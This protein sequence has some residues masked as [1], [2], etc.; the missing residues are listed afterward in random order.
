MNRKKI[1]AFIL[2]TSLSSP[3]ISQPL[4]V[5]AFENKEVI[6]KSE[7]GVKS[8]EDNNAESEVNENIITNDEKNTISVENTTKNVSVSDVVQIPDDNLKAALNEKLGVSQSDADITK[9][10]LESITSLLIE[11]R[12][13]SNLE[14]LQYCTNLGMLWLGDNQINDIS[15]LA[16]LTKL[17]TLR[18]NS[19]QISDISHLYNLT[20]LTQLDLTSNQISDIYSLASL[21][22]LT[23]LKLANNQI[24]D[25]SHLSSLTKLTNLIL[26]M[27]QTIDLNSLV[28][29]TNL[30]NLK[31]LELSNCQISDISSLE[32]ANWPNLTSLQL[33]KNQISDISPLA[34]L[35]SLTHLYL[36]NN[37]ISDISPLGNL[38]NLEY[39]HLRH[40]RISDVSPLVNW[41]NLSNLTDIYLGYNQISD[42][43]SLVNLN[44]PSLA[45]LDLA[46]NQISDASPLS[47]VRDNLPKIK[48]ITVDSQTIYL[49]TVELDSTS[50]EVENKIKDINGNIVDRITINN[51]GSYNSASKLVRWD[52][53]TSKTDLTYTF[54]ETMSMTGSGIITYFSGTVIQPYTIKS[55]KVTFDS[56]GGSNVPE[57]DVEFDSLIAKPT[58]PTREGYTFGGWY[59][60]ADCQNA[61]DFA[62]EKMPSNNVTLY[63]KWTRNSYNVNFDSQGGSAVGP[64]SVE[65]EGLVNKP[66]DPTREGYTFGGWY[67]D[68]T[69]A[70]AWNFDS[71]KMPSKDITLYAKWKRNEA[72]VIF[73]EG[74]TIKVGCEFNPL[75][76]VK[77]EDKEDGDIT[78]KIKVIENTVNTSKVGIYSVTYEVTDSNGLTTRKTIVVI[79]EDNK[80]I[81]PDEEN[82]N[83]NNSGNKVTI[84]EISN[85]NKNNNNSQNNNQ[86]SNG[87]INSEEDKIKD[88]I[89][90]ELGK[91]DNASDED[92]VL[93]WLLLLLA[94]GTL[95][96]TIVS[97][98]RFKKKIEELAEQNEDK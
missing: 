4:S 59:K 5:N 15:P 51:G 91:G 31:N 18:L 70:T 44:L 48:Q 53:L 35:T 84:T 97:R 43:S 38:N 25:V 39:L 46:S 49:P 77:A 21:T 87:T 6:S 89:K 10:Q 58:E 67:T 16:S 40:N 17:T 61:W 75:A 23:S 1:T 34:N 78:E 11:N 20:K 60:E 45:S 88:P 93:H 2:A 24:S 69:F 64:E 76:N 81:I 30:T 47:K 92:C 56:Q 57:A 28:K 37:E 3:I 86:N 42:I 14:G 83:N 36:Y 90:P 12:N 8:I 50:L 68:E 74:T 82:N 80:V 19:N 72:P 41:N 54:R 52:N 79:V 29:C 62:S 66:Q 27:N 96:G 65:F 85:S 63:A 95:G 32:N 9:S 7:Q 13:I 94:A 98:Q 33:Y 55:Y 73:A 71:D 26:S 22:N